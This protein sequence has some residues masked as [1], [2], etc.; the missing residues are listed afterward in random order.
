MLKEIS[1]QIILWVNDNKKSFLGGLIG[2]ILGVFILV[3]GFLKTIFLLIFT[4][5]GYL[6]GS[7]ILK[8]E[9]LRT[10][11]ERILPPGRTR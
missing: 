2:F 9:D 3:I 6:L 8:K 10:L 7:E 5:I 4:G 11:L 1:S